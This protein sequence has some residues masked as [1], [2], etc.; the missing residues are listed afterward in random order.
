MAV[1][2]ATGAA[3]LTTVLD[4]TLAP[5]LPAAVTVGGHPLQISLTGGALPAA[6]ATLTVVRT[7]PVPAGQS[8][9]L[10]YY[11]EG[12]G[13]WHSVPSTLSPDRLSIAA[14]VHHFS[15]W[16]D[17]YYDVGKLATQRT[18]PPT[19][20]G[21]VPGWVGDSTFLD[22]PNAP[23]R[24]C[25]GAD[26]RH[27]DVVVL[28]V[29]NNRAYGFALRPAV[30]PQF[31][32]SSLASELGLED[33]LTAGLRG[34]LTAPASVV[35][36]LKGIVFLAP[37]TGAD[38]G[39]TQAQVRAAGT[40]PLLVA[41]RDPAWT[42]AGALYAAISKG[43]GTNTVGA[44]L[45]A[46]VGAIQCGHDVKQS[47][48]PALAVAELA[49]CAVKAPEAVKNVVIDLG[50][51][52]TSQSPKVIAKAAVAARAVML[53]IG[54]FFTGAQIG[55]FLG[56]LR[57]N[58][59]A[60]EAHIFPTI[61][62]RPKLPD[63]YYGEW[64]VHGGGLLISRDGTAFGWGHDGFTSSGDFL[65]GMSEYRMVASADGKSGIVTLTKTYYGVFTGSFSRQHVRTVPNPNPQY[66]GSE[67]IGD[68][69]SV[70]LLRPGL[71]MTSSLPGD[72]GPG[73]GPGNPYLCGPGISSADQN[74]CGA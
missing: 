60:F 40:A 67:Q 37:D 36:A 24:W 68:R 7:S 63:V 62:K 74:L 73:S 52:Y 30:A 9:A 44:F 27:P 59:A 34:T 23:L 64:G 10:A 28:K 42:V 33:L 50:V 8:A 56:D 66:P 12:A 15:I 11:D 45:F 5:P 48:T 16:D 19:C 29:R 57:V 47:G 72:V 25:V 13:A 69:Y 14:T 31:A 54:A 49:R 32:F 71:L 35:G 61:P 70:R 26:P 4:P 21:K 1:P 6:R 39:F 43:A 22:D 46:V 41:Q 38:F 2:A 58:G 53:E 65:Y 18:D 55:E 51:K 3:T 20:T 17:V